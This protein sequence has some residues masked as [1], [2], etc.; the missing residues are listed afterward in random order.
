MKLSPRE[1]F[2]VAEDA[3]CGDG[4]NVYAEFMLSRRSRLCCDSEHSDTTYTVP[5]SRFR[6][7]EVWDGIG[8]LRTLDI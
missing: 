6:A 5:A 7:K 3:V 8:M 1:G 4:S 2:E